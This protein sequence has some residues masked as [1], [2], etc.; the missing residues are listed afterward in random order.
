MA[1]TIGGAKARGV[2][3]VPEAPYHPSEAVEHYDKAN[4]SSPPPEDKHSATRDYRLKD[5]TIASPSGGN[6]SV[7]FNFANCSIFE[8]LFSNTMSCELSI[9]DTNNIVRHLPI[10][11][12]QEELTITFET[13]GTK[14]T[15]EFKFDIYAVRK[16][17]LPASGRKQVVTFSAVSTIMFKE[18]HTKISKAYY[19]T[20]TNIIKDICKEYLELP[21]EKVFIDVK[22][23]SEKIKVIIPNWSPLTAINW[24]VA[25]SRDEDVCNFVFYEDR[26]GFHL[27]TIDKLV[28]VEKP[29]MGYFYTP[30]KHR[31]YNTPKA[32]RGR[33]QVGYEFRNLEAVVFEEPGNRLDEVNSG[34]HSSRLLTHNIVTKSYEVTDYSM[35]KEYDNTKHV[36]ENYPICKDLDKFATE[37]DSV[38]D[39]KPKHKFLNQ[40][41]DLGGE[42]V[43][44]NDKYQDWFS[45][46]K[47]QMKQINVTRCAA[48]SAGD[49]RRKCGDI[50]YLQFAPLE[51]GKGD[52]DEKLDKYITG[53]YLVTSVRHSLAQDGGYL[54]DMEL[55]KDSVGG[56]PYPKQSKFLDVM[57]SN[58]GNF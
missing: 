25:R 54:M 32:V 56:K 13:P 29:H 28:D 1:R 31:D 47:S 15:I 43:E 17:I 12:Q 33:R 14:D 40:K 42:D 11:G 34:M 19:D 53:K 52:D 4:P 23:D 48:N 7:M 9:I 41:N 3:Q 27:T 46:R 38:F 44:D 20:T 50:V 24:L 39:F 26:E 21:D 51:P 2:Q 57:E 37:H 49:S 22:G 35:K 8:D 16:K 18:S 45:K 10:I 55:T 6:V 58:K 30:R 5:I 36:E